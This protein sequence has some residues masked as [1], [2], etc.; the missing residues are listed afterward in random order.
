DI[1]ARQ[2]AGDASKQFTGFDMSTK[3]KLIGVDVGSF[4]DPFCEQTP[5]IPIVFQNKQKG[6][7]KRINLSEDGKYLLGG[8][9]IGD[10]SAYNLLHQMTM[11]KML[12]PENPETLIVGGSGKAAE[13]SAGVKGLPDTAQLCS[14][15][16]ISKGELVNQVTNCGAKTL[17]DLKKSTK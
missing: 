14:C 2:I 15:E 4:G 3:L 8:I 9:L 7:Y 17:D 1:V 12:L 10:A 16:N 5:H 6:T 11:N 13:E